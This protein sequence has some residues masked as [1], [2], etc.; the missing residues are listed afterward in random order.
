ML[1]LICHDRTVK[2][3]FTDFQRPAVLLPGQKKRHMGKSQRRRANR[4]NASLPVIC[5]D[6]SY[7]CRQGQQYCGRSS[8]DDVR[9][10][11][12]HIECKRVEQLNLHDAMDQ[13][14]QDANALPGE[15]RPF[16]AVF[17]RR[18]HEEWLVTMRMRSGYTCT[19]NGNPAGNRVIQ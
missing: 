1:L 7:N 6:Y 16:P 15:G 19:A 14:V 4:V 12:I 11:G 3:T 8:A 10:S 5:Q 2:Y 17:H 18:D 13:A 9:P